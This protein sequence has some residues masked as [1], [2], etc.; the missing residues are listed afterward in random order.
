MS[1]VRW[2]ILSTASISSSF[3]K[4]IKKSDMAEVVAVASRYKSSADAWARQYDIPRSFPSYEGML[5]YKEMDAVYIPLPN[6]LHAQWAIK[7]LKAGFPVLCEKP[8]AVNA[9]EA[10]Q[11][12]EAAKECNLPVAEGFM[13]RFHPLFDKVQE[14]IADGQIGDITSIHSKF[15]Y[16]LDNP[17]EIPASKELAGGSLMDIGCYSINLSRLISGS[18]PLRVTAI[19]RRNDVDETMFGIL[20]FPSGILA[21][22]ECSISNFERHRAEISGTKG[23]IV[24]DDPWIPGCQNT[25]FMVFREEQAAE[26]IV[27]NGNDAYLLEIEDFSKVV[28]G[29]K[30][31][32]WPIEDAVNNMKVIDALFESART[33]QVT[34]VK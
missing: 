5:S 17:G 19:E 22:F 7:A 27:V 3:I 1:K 12:S 32:R 33:N 26:Q 18:E 10:Q 31:P 34:E 20:D 9:I 11:I 4:A 24:I 25:S 21:S 6:S 29:Q 15:T 28:A 23:S 14:L 13:Y 2:G 30:A 8:I 16:M